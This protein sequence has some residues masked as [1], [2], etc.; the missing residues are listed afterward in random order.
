MGG[1]EKPALR[2]ERGWPPF[3]P[4]PFHSLP[5]ALAAPTSSGPG[6]RGEQLLGPHLVGELLDA[7]LTLP[8][9]LDRLCVALL[10]GLQLI[11]QLPHTGLQLLQ[12]LLAALEG[13]LLSLVQPVLQVLDGGHWCPAPSSAPPPSS[14]PAG[15]REVTGGLAECSHAH[16]PGRGAPAW[17]RGVGWRLTSVMAFLAFSSAFLHSCTAS[18]TSV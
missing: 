11:L 16:R 14:R 8:H 1:R 10:L 2:E 18:S 5:C 13:D 6:P 17:S 9:A 3:P 15:R 12:L 7:T 4:S